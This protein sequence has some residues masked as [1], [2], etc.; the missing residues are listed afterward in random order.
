MSVTARRRVRLPEFDQD[1]LSSHRDDVISTGTTPA[2]PLPSAAM[3]TPEY[4]RVHANAPPSKLREIIKNQI[5]PRDDVNYL[6]RLVGDIGKMEYVYRFLWYDGPKPVS[7]VEWN[8]TYVKSSLPSV[9]RGESNWGSSGAARKVAQTSPSANNNKQPQSPMDRHPKARKSG[10]TWIQYC[11][12]HNA[13]QCLQWIFHE[14]VKHHLEKV[15]QDQERIQQNAEHALYGSLQ[16]QYPS[17]QL[18]KEGD[19]LYIIKQLL[20]YPSHCYCATN[21]V[22][23]GA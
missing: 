12:Y 21:Y 23:V 17:R 7:S 13:H 2:E 1:S 16:R 11:C 14:V 3:T 20:E 15:Q 18:S 10:R 6:K 8:D 4:L 22:A 19:L 5:F 9:T